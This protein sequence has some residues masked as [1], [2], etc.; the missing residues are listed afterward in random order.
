MCS[1]WVA[2]TAALIQT[3]G[4]K[5]NEQGNA[6]ND[7]KEPTIEQRFEIWKIVAGTLKRLGD[8]NINQLRLF[9]GYVIPRSFDVLNDRELLRW[10]IESTGKA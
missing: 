10:W 6:E 7:A 2:I 9:A 4:W 3:Y 1:Q 8:C 5:P